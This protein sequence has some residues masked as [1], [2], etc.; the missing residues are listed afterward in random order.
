MK[1]LL[2]VLLLTLGLYRQA[3]EDQK[4]QMNAR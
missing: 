3:W 2:A 4:K 1:G